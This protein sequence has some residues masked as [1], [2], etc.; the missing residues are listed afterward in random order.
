MN[1]FLELDCAKKTF[2]GVVLKLTQSNIILPPTKKSAICSFYT[3]DTDK[4]IQEDY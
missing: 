3:K 4:Y 2:F 1:R